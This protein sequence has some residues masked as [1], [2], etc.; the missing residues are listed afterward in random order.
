V[1]NLVATRPQD[2]FT[3]HVDVRPT[4]MTLT[5]LSDDYSNDGRTI[6]EMLYPSV[7]P[8]SFGEPS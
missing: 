1:S 4:L 7:L 5:G 8:V 2:Y 6:V 3:D